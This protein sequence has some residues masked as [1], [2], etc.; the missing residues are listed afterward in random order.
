MISIRKLFKKKEVTPE[1]KLPSQYDVSNILNNIREHKSYYAG[2]TLCVDNVIP[3]DVLMFNLDGEYFLF[4]GGR[5]DTLNFDNRNKLFAI[6]K[7][8]KG[9]TNYYKTQLDNF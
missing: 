5:R 2:G 8:V 6:Y 3:N 7:E 9:E 1:V 4:S